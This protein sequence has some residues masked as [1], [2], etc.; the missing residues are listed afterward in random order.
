MI[1]TFMIEATWTFWDYLFNGALLIG[2]VSLMIVAV[3][4]VMRLLKKW[5]VSIG[6][7]LKK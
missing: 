1:D 5:I 3:W 6:K 2:L 7:E 4:L